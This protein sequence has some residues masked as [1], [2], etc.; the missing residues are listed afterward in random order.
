MI[1]KH[2]VTNPKAKNAI[3]D[4]TF[5]SMAFLPEK[6]YFRASLKGNRFIDDLKSTNYNVGLS[7]LPFRALS[8]SSA[9]SKV[10]STKNCNSGTIRICLPIRFPNSPLI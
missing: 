5:T 9:L 6:T 4:I 7:P 1:N 2:A 10:T 8:I 3:Q